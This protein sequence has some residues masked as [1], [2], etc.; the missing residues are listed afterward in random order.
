MKAL[1]VRQPQV[2]LQGLQQ[3]KRQGGCPEDMQSYPDG[4][5]ERETRGEGPSESPQGFL[6]SSFRSLGQYDDVIKK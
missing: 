4:F 6:Q 2:S 3:I 5:H 1:S